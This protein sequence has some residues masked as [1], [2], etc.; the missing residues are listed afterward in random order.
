MLEAS[1]GIYEAR[2]RVTDAGSFN[3]SM[4]VGRLRVPDGQQL[5]GSTATINDTAF[6]TTYVG[7]PLYA[8]VMVPNVMA[9]EKFTSWEAFGAPSTTINNTMV[10][11]QEQM[12]RTTSS[13]QGHKHRHKKHSH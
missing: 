13:R 6:Y 8:T 5:I 7:S 10:A 1:P 11:P 4:L 12:R 3:N 9:L 2:Y